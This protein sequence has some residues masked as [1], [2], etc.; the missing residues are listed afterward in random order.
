MRL[1]KMAETEDR[2][3]ELIEAANAALGEGDFGTADDLL[4]EAEAVQLR[5]EHHRGLG[6]PSEAA[7]R[8]GQRRA[9]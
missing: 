2:I 5:V 4:K 3:S 9:R 6:E 1:E 8:T 7:D